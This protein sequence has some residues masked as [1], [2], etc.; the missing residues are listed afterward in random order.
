M[1]PIPNK[2][3]SRFAKCSGAAALLGLDPL[4]IQV[5]KVVFKKR[6]IVK[7]RK[8][9]QICELIVSRSI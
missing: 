1:T 9:C 2:W 6:T 4:G 3:A 7:S 8:Y 5:A